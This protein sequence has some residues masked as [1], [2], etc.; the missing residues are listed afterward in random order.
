MSKGEW[1]MPK[2]DVERIVDA[3]GHILEDKEAIKR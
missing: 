3:D 1:S 2:G